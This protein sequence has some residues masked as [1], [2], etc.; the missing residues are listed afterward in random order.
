LGNPK[1][2][3]QGNV[4]R[5]ANQNGTPRIMGGAELRNWFQRNYSQLDKVNVLILAP[6]KL[7]IVTNNIQ[8]TT[9]RIAYCKYFD[10]RD[11]NNRCRRRDS[12]RKITII[13]II[14]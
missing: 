13:K 5:D 14:G 3:I 1:V 2:Q 7:L 11:Q 6:D 4:N 9:R 8:Q 10:H 12:I